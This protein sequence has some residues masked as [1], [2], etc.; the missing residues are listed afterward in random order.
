MSG[1]ASQTQRP[2]GALEGLRVVELTSEAA[3]LAGKLLADMG[4]EVIVVEPPSGSI[5][6]SRPPFAEDIE[7]RERSLTWWHYNT[8][9]L[10]V[11]LD[12]DT[13]ADRERFRNLIRVAD[14]VLESEPPGR[15]ADLGLDY[16]NL[17]ELKSDLVMVSVTPF[18]RGGPRRDEVA[19]DLTVLAAGGPV[20]SS[21]YDDHSLP[22]I[23]GW[24]NQGY[25]IASL[26]AV[27]GTLIAILVRD[28]RGVGQHVDV[29]MHA[30]AN[31]TTEQ[32]TYTWLVARQTVQRQTGRHAETNPTMPTQVQCSDGFWVNTGVPPRVRSEFIAVHDW[33]RELGLLGEFSDRIL[34]ELGMDRERLDLSKLGEDVEIQAIFGAGREAMTLIASR[35]PSYEYFMGAHKRGMPVAIIYSP[36]E[37]FEDPHFKA[38]GFPT[39]VEH[40]EL[41][42]SIPYPGAPIRFEGSPWRI[43]GRAPQLGEHNEL[44]FESLAATSAL[45]T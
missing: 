13:E 11:T 9:K 23:R 5:L 16:A 1:N 33:L 42:K 12:L 40:P 14:I 4:A 25:N 28:E 45:R 39:P 30:A 6:R 2:R 38:R 19:T 17:R 34:L 22:P 35:L 15:M 20:W 32:A 7:D 21:G 24:G 31:V 44:V 18:G 8:S 27:M 43:R 26:Y 41:G 36:E 37:V 29:N 10:G 3:A